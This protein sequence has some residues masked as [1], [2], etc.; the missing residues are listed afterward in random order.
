[1]CDIAKRKSVGCKAAREVPD[2]GGKSRGVRTKGRDD[3]QKQSLR[4]N[5]KL[6]KP[7]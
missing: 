3:K 7:L 2:V 4:D 5:K 1:M 6:G